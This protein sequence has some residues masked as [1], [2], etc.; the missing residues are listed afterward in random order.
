MFS[1]NQSVGQS[2]HL[3]FSVSGVRYAHRLPLVNL[4]YVSMMPIGGFK[5]HVSECS[6]LVP[7][8]LSPTSQKVQSSLNG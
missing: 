2:V 7:A 4:V 1:Q 5:G 3:F 6:V 8:S